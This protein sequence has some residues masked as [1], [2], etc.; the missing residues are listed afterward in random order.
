MGYA[1]NLSQKTPAD[2]LRSHPDGGITL[3]RPRHLVA[4][5]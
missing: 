5:F 1:M 2:H 3:L 4:G